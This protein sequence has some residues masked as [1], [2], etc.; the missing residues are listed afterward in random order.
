MRTAGKIS[1]PI[2]I[3]TVLLCL[4]FLFLWFNA[5]VKRNGRSTLF[6][7]ENGENVQSVADKLERAGIIR[8]DL[9]FT[10]LVRLTKSSKNV[11]SGV[12]NL[13][14]GMHSTEVLRIV[15]LG[16]VAME[17][18]TIPE[19]LH[20]KQVARLL[21]KDGIVDGN[22]F[23]MACSSRKILEKYGIPF[24]SAEGFIFPDTYV[25]AKDLSAEQIVDIAVERFFAA[26]NEVP[27]SG[28]SS[29]ELK[30]VIIVASLVE[31]EA[32]LDEERPIIAAVFYNRLDK[33]KRLEACSTIQYILGKT[34]ER[35]LYSDLKIQ[36]PYNTYLN[37]GLPPGPIA[38][39]GLKSLRAAVRPADVDYLFFVS[40]KDGSH[41][42]SS[43]YAEHL[44][45]I[46]QYGGAKK[47]THQMS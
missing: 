29:E 15:T 44:E 45:A 8:S 42:F 3:C 38:N 41:H 12:Y 16:I 10:T 18:F 7:I 27:F 28:F 23:I 14:G 40:K 37:G 33:G 5:P 31:K 13:D 30:R 24:V 9:F 21:E 2:A 35:L 11:K 39:P 19:G 17:K 46:E 36:S 6:S 32:K 25:V 1:T 47:F 43:T 22:E 20:I 26:L 4:F 34:K